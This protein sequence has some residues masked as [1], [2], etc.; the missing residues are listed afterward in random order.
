MEVTGPWSME[1]VATTIENS[2]LTISELYMELPMTEATWE[3]KGFPSPIA[4]RGH[5]RKAV[6]LVLLLYCCRLLK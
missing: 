6:L 3:E 4:G 1:N 2:A 5:Q